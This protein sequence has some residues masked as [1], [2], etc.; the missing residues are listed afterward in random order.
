MAGKEVMVSAPLMV[1]L[2]DRTFVAGS[3][4]EA[5]RRRWQFH[6]SLAATWL[7]LAYLVAGTAT[8]GGTAGFDTVVTSWS[9]ALTQCQAVVHYLRLAVWP[10]PLVFDYGTATVNS[11]AEVWPQ[12]LLLIAIVG[13]TVVAL[14]R[15]PAWG[16]LGA[17]F[18]AIL[19]PSSSVVPVAS[20]TM[21]EHRMYLSLAA[22]VVLAVVGLHVWLGRR[23]WLACAA[24][25]VGF[26][27]LTAWRNEDYHSELGIWADTVAKR[28][29]NARAHN[30]LGKAVFT[31][32][33]T[34]ESVEHYQEAIRLQPTA[35]EPYYNLGLALARL[36]RR[37]EAIAQYEEALRLQPKYPDAHNNL[38]N[39]MLEGGRLA[40]AAAHYEE[41]LRLKPDFA[42]AHSNLANVL[43]EM[44]RGPEAIH[45]GEEAVRLDPG[46]AEARLNLGNAFA[47]SGRLEPA[48][49]QYREAVRLKPDYADVYNNMGNALA[50]LDRLPEAIAQYEQALRLK[51]DYADPRRNLAQMLVHL[52]R[53]PEAI[54]HYQILVQLRPGDQAARAELTRLQAMVR[55]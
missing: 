16:F 20:Q 49:L 23:S 28:P 46:Y 18:L 42:E 2:Y 47:Q 7:L 38:G 32:G 6:L 52:D 3:F 54:N 21:A 55:P 31:L 45:H 53:L 33:H 48:L 29:A 12:A 41:A 39:A 36:N 24:L 44:D 19:A 26:G 25:A 43:L 50:G 10:H 37:P 27:G 34:A 5:W 17:W 14:W 35:P 13:G 15:R 22:V 40:E 1:F 4:K 9:Y 30:N 11:L 8:R 51:P